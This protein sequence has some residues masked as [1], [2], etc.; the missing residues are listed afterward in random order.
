VRAAIAAH[1]RRNL[2]DP[3]RE[4]EGVGPGLEIEAAVDH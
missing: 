2:V 1:W 4:P 3:I